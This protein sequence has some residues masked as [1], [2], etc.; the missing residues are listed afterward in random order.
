MRTHVDLD[1]NLLDQVVQLGRF[2]TKKAAIQAALTEFVKTLKR[3]QLL[4]LR[5]Q[6]PWQGDL[7]QL[8]A[9]PNLEED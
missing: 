2:P 3:R 8:R 5:G 6:V 4:A 1:E 9:R 7:D